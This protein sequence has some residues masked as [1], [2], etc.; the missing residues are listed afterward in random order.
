MEC[1]GKYVIFGRV[2]EGFD[3]VDWLESVGHGS[4]IPKKTVVIADSGTLE[5]GDV[6]DAWY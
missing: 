3:V 4:G 6:N 1:N 2:V 5:L